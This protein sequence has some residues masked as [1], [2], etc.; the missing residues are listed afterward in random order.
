MKRLGLIIVLTCM[1]IL[2]TMGQ[3]ININGIKYEH[4][5]NYKFINGKKVIISESALVK[6][7]STSLSGKVT[8]PSQI[9]Y[10]GKSIAVT[11]ILEYAFKN[12][13][14]ITSIVVPSGI[15]SIGD[16][17]FKNCTA[18][19]NIK[20]PLKVTRIGSG[21]FYN[22]ISLLFVELPQIKNDWGG[23]EKLA[24]DM[25]YGCSSL[26]YV[27]IPSTIQE[28][29]TG[30]FAYCTSLTDVFCFPTDVPF[31]KYTF[32]GLDMGKIKIHVPNAAISQYRNYEWNQFKSI[33]TN[34]TRP[35]VKRQVN[36]QDTESNKNEIKAIDMGGSV[37]WANMN[38]GATTPQD[39]GGIF[40]WGETTSRTGDFN[41]RNYTAPKL[42]EK[43]RTLYDGVTG[44][45]YDA[46]RIQWGN[47]WRMPT[48]EEFRELYNKC[49][50]I[51]NEKGEYVEFVASNGNRLILP[52]LLSAFIHRNGI[53]NFYWTS[54]QDFNGAYC[55]EYDSMQ[56]NS[57]IIA[58]IH[59]C[60]GGLIRPVRDKR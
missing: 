31:S 8:I 59:G 4:Y 16:Y 35:Q 44:S 51:V 53:G 54:N 37:E 48:E 49:R 11:S 5:V 34:M 42:T 28:I 22:C 29:G 25:F 14:Q 60:Y 15:G 3:P 46:A 27:K 58:T 9:T 32:E 40:A 2:T 21:A 20:L 36:T 52:I 7:V 10:K 30:A 23:H 57:F 47:G 38:L 1:S 45:K 39:P 55:C 41:L 12:C 24:N 33:D 18:L 50:V 56:R 13:S 6:S 19:T 17:A 26:V 43:G